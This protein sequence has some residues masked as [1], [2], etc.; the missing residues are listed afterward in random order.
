M[1][2]CS[3]AITG[4]ELRFS[5]LAG[6]EPRKP[7][8]RTSDADLIRR[9]AG[10]DEGAMNLLYIRHSTRIFRFAARL[11]GDRTAA[12][13]IVSE[14]F[15]AVWRKAGSFEARAQVSTW[16][17]SI[18]RNLAFGAMRQPASEALDDDLV[19]GIEDPAADPEAHS[20]TLNT[21]AIMRKCL[22]Q[23]SLPHREIVDLIYYHHKSIEE[24]SEIVG[25]GQ[26]TVKTRMHYARKHLA[27][28][29][30]AQGITTT[31]M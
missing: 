6:S 13:D 18:A 23:L 1:T 9:I 22:A 16:L 26:N 21:E 19:D 3:G 5:P 28:L 17:L 15:L 12:E 14:V 7:N 2:I 27:H 29:L 11:L 8:G 10:G 20:E 25:V 4:N 24:A 30:A 31:R